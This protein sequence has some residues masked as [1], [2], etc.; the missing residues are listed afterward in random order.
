MKEK[1]EDLPMVGL[2]VLDLGWVWS[3][4]M[5]S[6]MFADLGAEVIKVEHN[7]RLDNTRL[8][9]SPTING[10]RIEGKSI[11]LGPYFHN[12]NRNKLS[13]TLN[14]RVR[15]GIELFK[16]LVRKSDVI[17]EN[18]T[19]K[20]LQK[21]GLGYEDLKK[22]RPDLIMLSLSTAG[23][24]GPLSDVKGYAPVISS[25]SGME[26]LVGYEG[27]PSLGMMTFGMSDPS[28]A[29]QAFFSV[30]VALYYREMTGEG[31]YIDMS[32]LEASV[33]LLG[34]AIMEYIMNGRILEPMGNFHKTEAP[35]G[36][37]PTLEEDRW[38]AV[39]AEAE[40]EW[41]GLVRAMGDPS[42]V[43]DH[44][45]DSKE[46]RLNNRKL[47][48]GYLKEWTSKMS[49]EEILLRLRKEG[50][51]ATSVLSMEEQ[52]KDEHFRERR[53]HQKVIHPLLGEEIL[54]SI[55]WN[56]ET[57]GQIKR[58]APLLGEHN[59]YVFGEVLGLSHEEIQRLQLEKVI[60]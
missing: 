48:D 40:E 20:T 55:P 18:F 46:E 29:A 11:E 14:L 39:S 12:L 49:R 58:S 47:L 34:E 15:K 9:G 43:K 57:G 8:R 35:Y 10:K 2:R 56:M 4:P 52:Y 51:P 19:P 3:G 13:I 24:S 53:I 28:A 6:Y 38:V 16:S 27:E 33:V 26:S 30:M 59:N 37:Y 21:L 42:W 36:I 44:R 17:I 1:N 54:F 23:Q 41:G 60:Y 45:F 32:Q 25:L 22:L 7:E 31:K 50:V 5:V